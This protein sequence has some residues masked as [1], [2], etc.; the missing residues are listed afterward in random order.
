MKELYT[1][2]KQGTQKFPEM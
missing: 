1:D 2:K